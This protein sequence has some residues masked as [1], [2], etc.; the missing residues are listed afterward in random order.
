MFS[1]ICIL[2]YFVSPDFGGGSDAKSEPFF[3]VPLSAS[4]T[5]SLGFDVTFFGGGNLLVKPFGGGNLLVKPFGG[6]NLPVEPFGGGND[7]NRD[8]F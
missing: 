1:N 7:E 3:F 4:L 5:A 6:G 8:L 2:N